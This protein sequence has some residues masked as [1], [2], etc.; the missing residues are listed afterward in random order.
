MMGDLI[1]VLVKSPSTPWVCRG[2][3]VV[4]DL[5]QTRGFY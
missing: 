5:T 4:G 1:I 3:G 2:E